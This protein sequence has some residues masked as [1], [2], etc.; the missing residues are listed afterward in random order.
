M[1]RRVLPPL[2]GVDRE[3]HVRADISARDLLLRDWRRAP[4]QRLVVTVTRT[5]AGLTS[6]VTEVA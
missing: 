1:I 5:P 3:H 4:R 6:T 2:M